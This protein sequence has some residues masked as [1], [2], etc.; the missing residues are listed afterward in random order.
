MNRPQS[1]VSAASLQ[2]IRPGDAR[3]AIGQ[4]VRQLRQRQDLTQP[5]LASKSGVPTS[6]ISRLEREGEGSLDSFFRVLMALGELD[7]FHSELKDR[8]RISNL[9][10]D[11]AEFK[12]P[13]PPRQR[14]RISRTAPR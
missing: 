12:T 7:R 3:A 6:T 5:M 4:W 2:L 8:L 10:R 9:P 11:L 13:T 14:V 1:S